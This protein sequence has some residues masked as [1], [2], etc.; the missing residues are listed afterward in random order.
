MIAYSTFG[1]N[2]MARSVAFYDALFA[3]LGAVRAG[4]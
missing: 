3:P 4:Q 2:D 1:V